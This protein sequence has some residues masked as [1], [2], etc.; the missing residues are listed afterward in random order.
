MF[1]I[2][3]VTDGDIA[4]F[5]AAGLVCKLIATARRT[6][7]GVAAWLEPTLVDAHALE[8]AVPANYNLISFQSAY[9]GRQ[10]YFGQ[11]AGRYP[12]ASNVVQDCV[13]ILHGQTSFYTSAAEAMTPDNSG[14]AHAYYVR[15]AAPDAWLAAHTAGSLGSGTLTVP[16]SVSEML[17]WAKAQ[18]TVDPTA[19]IAAL[20]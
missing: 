13:D 3:T 8:A 6:D 19:F 2:R 4:Q 11:G 12:T 10:S 20:A 18:L 17:A 1:G 9:L 14:I 15:T 5:K 16:V 7:S